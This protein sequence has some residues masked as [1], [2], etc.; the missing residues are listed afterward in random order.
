MAD[1]YALAHSS[2]TL[3]ARPCALL[4]ISGADHISLL[5]N[6]LT[7]DIQAMKPGE[8]KETALLNATSHVLAYMHAVKTESSILLIAAPGNFQKIKSL[9]EKFII[10]EDVSIEDASSL[11]NYY[12]AWGQGLS[13]PAADFKSAAEGAVPRTML[14]SRAKISAPEDEAAREILRIENGFLEYGPD[15]NENIML[16]ETRREKIS[17]SGTKGCYPGQEVVA[18]IETYKRL[19]RS[20]VR[21]VFEEDI[22]P[23]AGSTIFDAASGEEIGCLTSRTRSPFYQ[24]TLGLG[25]L[26]RG[27]FEKPIKVSVKSETAVSGETAFLDH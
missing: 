9:L 7:Q 27:F 19:N 22:V 20:F 1:V 21:I 24:K 4:E 25:W 17:A 5:Q 26:R 13:L 2:G 23:A 12:E 18:K 8:W 14:L 15:I 16:S 11:W 6:I 10:T 3:I